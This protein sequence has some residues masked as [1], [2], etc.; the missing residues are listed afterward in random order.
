M[1]GEKVDIKNDTEAN[2]AP[3][4]A[5]GRHPNLFTKAAAIGPVRK[6]IGL[7]KVNRYTHRRRKV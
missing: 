7:V 4:M 1:L 5:T 6:Q 2:A 3:A